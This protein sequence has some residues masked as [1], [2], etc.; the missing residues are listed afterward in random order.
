ML[1]RSVR[2]HLGPGTII[3]HVSTSITDSV[4]ADRTAPY[5]AS[6][7]EQTEYREQHTLRLYG[8]LSSEGVLRELYATSVPDMP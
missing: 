1:A 7:P 5:A 4:T 2:D 3:L 8:I 6:V